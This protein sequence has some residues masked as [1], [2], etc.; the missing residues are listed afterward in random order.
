[1]GDRTL[2]VPGTQGTRLLDSRGRAVYDAVL[3]TVGFFGVRRRSLGGRYP[4][5]RWGEVVR[6]EHEP[7]RWEP[8]RT[9]GLDGIDLY[10]GEVLRTPYNG[11]F[12]E[13]Q[14][15]PYDWRADIRFSA[16]R[17]L[18]HLKVHR[19]PG[20]GRWNLIGHSQ[21]G[22]ILLA[23][24]RIVDD[25]DDL[26]RLVARIVLVGAPLAGTMRAANALL[27][28]R[29]DLGLER[30]AA[31]R[32]AARTW[33]S[34]YQMLPMWSAVTGPKGSPREAAFQLTEPGAWQGELDGPNAIDPGLLER[35]RAFHE[36]L[37]DPFRDVDAAGVPVLAVFGSDRPTPVRVRWDGT[38]YRP[39]SEEDTEGGDTL[40]PAE[41]TRRTFGLREGERFY[42]LP[43]LN[44]HALL[45]R[46]DAVVQ[47]V[48]RF[49]VERPRVAEAGGR[50]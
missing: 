46:D 8:V 4:A 24:A 25:P 45:C 40:V 23:L 49:L 48:R 26:R 27:F 41:T 18:E 28:G 9:S 33:P 37:A 38:W 43:R 12:G 16:L 35:A 20:R 7:G 10:P 47:L 36:I 2:L 32:G 30:A 15:F 1:M 21:G 17:L 19:P 44:E 39:P 42:A 50:G 34:L 6:M 22:L 5:V 14:E 13:D 11:S 3:A 31:M 29:D